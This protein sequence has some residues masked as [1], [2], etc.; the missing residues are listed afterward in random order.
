[1]RNL[2]GDW[3]VTDSHGNHISFNFCVYSESTTSG[4]EKDSFGFMKQGSK[5]LELTSDEPQ[6][7]LNDFVERASQVKG[8]DQEGIRLTRAGGA[9]CPEDTS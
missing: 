6:A 4:C 2:D 7:E 5:C 8:E 3:Q 9:T 1:M